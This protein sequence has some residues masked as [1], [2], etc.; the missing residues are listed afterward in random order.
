MDVLGVAGGKGSVWLGNGRR[1]ENLNDDTPQQQGKVTYPDRL[2]GPRDPQS[3][4][5]AGNHEGETPPRL[6]RLCVID[7]ER[8]SDTAM[9]L[10]SGVCQATSVSA[11]QCILGSPRVLLPRL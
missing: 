8:L 5:L 2:M 6:V 3:N 4:M 10:L 7:S 1:R 11:C 9:T